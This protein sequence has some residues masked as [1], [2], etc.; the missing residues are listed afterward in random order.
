MMFASKRL[1]A[2]KYMLQLLMHG[3]KGKFPE[4]WQ[5]RAKLGF[6]GLLKKRARSKEI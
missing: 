5:K 4:K 6:S 2:K 3:S 1:D